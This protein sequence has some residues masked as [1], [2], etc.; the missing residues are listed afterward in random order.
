MLNYFLFEY[1]YTKDILSIYL[2]EPQ[3][4]GDRS[5][6]RSSVRLWLRLVH[7]GIRENLGTDSW[8]RPTPKG[9]A[10]R[11]DEKDGT[12]AYGSNSWDRR[13]KHRLVTLHQKLR[14]GLACVWDRRL[15]LAR[16]YSPNA[17]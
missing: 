12:V 16:L 2:Y 15:R 4:A 13:H 8:L 9:K 11:D 14:S 6:N 7:A 10:I 5:R 1:T 3:L 17:S